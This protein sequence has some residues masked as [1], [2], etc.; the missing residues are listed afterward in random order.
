[1]AGA[2]GQSGL[3]VGGSTPHISTYFRA[4]QRPAVYQL[5]GPAQICTNK[6]T[7]MDVEKDNLNGR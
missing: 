6:D 2:G 7:D 4:G 5:L 3:G 1:V